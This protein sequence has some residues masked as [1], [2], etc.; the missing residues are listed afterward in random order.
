MFFRALLML[1][2]CLH[3]NIMNFSKFTILIDI[4]TYLLK[5]FFVVILNLGLFIFV[6]LI[7][8]CTSMIFLKNKFGKY[9]LI[10]TIFLILVDKTCG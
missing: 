4:K 5:E 2:T 1:V 9:S 3:D 7:T 6:L 10:F 8:F